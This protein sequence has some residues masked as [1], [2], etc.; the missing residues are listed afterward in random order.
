MLTNDDQ[1]R[2][3]DIMERVFQTR[4][5]RSCIPDRDEDLIEE[6]LFNATRRA[7]R[8]ELLRIESESTSIGQQVEAPALNSENLKSFPQMGQVKNRFTE[9]EV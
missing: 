3:D 6:I 9:D 5:A 7:R 2:F 1:K 4:E 8:E